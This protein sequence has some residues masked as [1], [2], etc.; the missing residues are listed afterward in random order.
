MG[1]ELWVMGYELP[2][3]RQGKGSTLTTQRL[4]FQWLTCLTYLLQ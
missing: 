3:E 2:V 1:Y 4:G